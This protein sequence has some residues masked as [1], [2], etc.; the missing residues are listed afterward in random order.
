MSVVP[1]AFLRELYDTAVAAVAPDVCVPPH[2]P[3]PRRG[4]TLVVG[5]GKGAAAMARAVE[6]RWPNEI[7][8]LVVTRY[9]HGVACRRIEVVE[10]GHPFPDAAGQ[11][12]ARRIYALAESAG[13]DDLVLCLLSGGGS[14]SWRPSSP[15]RRERRRARLPA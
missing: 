1:R 2:L 15:I 7:N 5:A 11:E 6:D 14:A 8:G 13:P 10:A 3:S 12:A 9:G 4:R